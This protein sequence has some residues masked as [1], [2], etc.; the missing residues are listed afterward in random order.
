VSVSDLVPYDSSYGH[1]WQFYVVILE[2][3]IL[4][5]VTFMKADCLQTC[6]FFIVLFCQ[7]TAGDLFIPGFVF[8]EVAKARPSSTKVVCCHFSSDG[9]LLA[10][11]GHDKV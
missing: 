2:L 11:G 4:V 8:F 10:T 9:K 7:F 3:V 6:F 1:L 5:L